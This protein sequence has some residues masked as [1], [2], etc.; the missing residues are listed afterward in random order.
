MLARPSLCDL[1]AWDP[2]APAD[3]DDYQRATDDLEH[4]KQRTE[5]LVGSA[6][7]DRCVTSMHP[8]DVRNECL[9][10]LEIWME[11]Q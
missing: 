1:M 4:L 3:H 9:A 8:N 2:A 5:R 6:L 10:A 11:Q 7:Y